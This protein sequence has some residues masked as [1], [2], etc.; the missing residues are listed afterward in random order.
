MTRKII[1]TIIG[2]AISGVSGYLAAGFSWM[3]INTLK[4]NG[5]YFTWV[6]DIIFELFYTGGPVTSDFMNIIHTA[7][8]VTAYVLI[9]ALTMAF[10]Y[11]VMTVIFGIID[12][13]KLKKED[14]V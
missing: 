2:M 1:K 13:V 7:N 11:G 12:I 10:T 6:N 9:L 3:I 14:R 4:G 8:I 5:N